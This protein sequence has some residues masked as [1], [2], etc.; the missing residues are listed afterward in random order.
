MSESTPPHR[1]RRL[2]PAAALLALT[3]FVA[4]CGSGAGSSQTPDD[5]AEPTTATEAPAA[6][7]AGTTSETGSTSALASILSTEAISEALGEAPTPECDTSVLSPAPA[8]ASGLL[9]TGPG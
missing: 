2:V 3:A 7:D 4:A 1:S 5:V 6:T 8:R 9:P